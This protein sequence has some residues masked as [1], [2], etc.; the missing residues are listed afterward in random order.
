LLSPQQ[1][2]SYSPIVIPLNTNL[3][4]AAFTPI[5]TAPVEPTIEI[6]SAD[7]AQPTAAADGSQP[8][9]V[10]RSQIEADRARRLGERFKLPDLPTWPSSQQHYDP[11]QELI[12]VQKPIRMRIHRACHNCNTAFGGSKVC[13]CG[14]TRCSEC[15]RTPPRKDRSVTKPAKSPARS[16]AIEVDD[17]HNLYA[18][19]KYVL[20]MP[21]RTGGQP[22]VMKKAV[23]RVRRTCHEC[24]TTFQSGT[25]VCAQCT[26]RRCVDCPR[27]P[28]KKKNYPDGYP[29]DAPSSD[30][31]KPVKFN[32][33]KCN[34]TY[35][36]VLPDDQQMAEC[37]RCN[38][39]RCMLT[40]IHPSHGACTHE[41]N[42]CTD[43]E[44]RWEM[45]PST[46]QKDGANTRPRCYPQSRSQTRRIE[47]L[48]PRQYA[49]LICRPLV[50]ITL[51]NSNDYQPVCCI[52]SRNDSNPTQPF[53][54]F[55]SLRI[56]S[57]C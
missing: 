19:E 57:A 23:Q 34:K 51:I 54:H 38:H 30:M 24:K 44:F 8:I 25:K 4:S 47:T 16:D 50:T 48:F 39:Q 21:S 15:P 41:E 53:L 10:L 6:D 29:G 55:Y 46:V 32:C 27:D 56:H 2:L 12:R 42:Q 33:H 28:A 11:E 18:T 7:E 9:K 20:T 36:P 22:L 3:T 5:A 45:L 31:S 40:P 52:R 13:V 14:H 35:P 49:V 17:Y 1:P 43:I 26:H 37:E